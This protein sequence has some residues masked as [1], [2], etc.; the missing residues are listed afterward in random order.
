MPTEGGDNKHASPSSEARGGFAGWIAGRPLAAFWL[1]LVIALAVGIGIGAVSAT[2][3]QL[4]DDLDQ[5]REERSSAEE[6]RDEAR[7]ELEEAEDGLEEANARARR[8]ERRANR[9]DRR[10][11]AAEEPAPVEEAPAP[12]S[13]VQTF[14]GNGGKNLGTIEVAEESLLEWTN[15]GDIFQI[16]GDDI[17]IMVNS[18]ASSGDTVVPAGSYSNVSVNAI[19]NWTITIGP[20]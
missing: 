4:R 9:A 17:A 1:T 19:G 8:L 10:A 11:A 15:D 6:E 7:T 20:R 2:D 12:S 13:E 5:A 14:T 18:Q 16:F 3:T